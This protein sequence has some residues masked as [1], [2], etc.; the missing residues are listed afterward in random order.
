MSDTASAQLDCDV[1]IIGAGPTGL[2]LACELLRHGLS[3]RILDAVENPTTFSK[4]Q[5]LHT[6]TLEVLEQMGLVEDF[7]KKGRAL[8]LLSMY[9]PDLRRIFHFTVGEFDSAYP[10]MLSL[11]QHDTEQIL[12][13]HLAKHGVIVERPFHVERLQQED[14]SVLVFGTRGPQQTPAQV[15]A[16]WA[17]GCDGANSVVRH[18]LNIP[19]QGSTYRQRVLQADVK[20]EWPLY[21]AEDEVFGFVSE[22]GSLGV[23]PLPAEGRYRLVAL[24]AGLSPTPENFQYLLNT[25]GPKE[26]RITDAAWLHEYTIH[27][28]LATAFRQGRV[29]LAGDAAHTLS[30]STAQGMNLGI[31]DAFNLAWK[32]ALVHKHIGRDILLDSYEA[33]RSPVAAELMKTSDLATRGLNDLF[34][35]HG[36]LAQSM[37]NSLLQLVSEFGLVRRSIS[38]NLSMLD[39][40]YPNSPIVDQH[41]ASRLTRARGAS[42]EALSAG[43]KGTGANIGLRQWLD[44]GHGPSPGQRAFDGRALDVTSNQ[45]RS[46]YSLLHSGQ[47]LLLLFAGTVETEDGYRRLVAIGKHLRERHP[48]A[49]SVYLVEATLHSETPADPSWDGPTLLD[50]DGWLHQTYGA[51]AECL[52]LIRPDGHVAFR[53]QPADPIK[54][55][56][57]LARVFI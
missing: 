12:I 54:L 39:L 25:R 27:C 53:S 42:A 24:D 1:L 44:F 10:Y 18:E 13:D 57:F 2:A 35:L 45:K 6:R 4:A 21:H 31:Q 41:H 47:H 11:P 29:F 52:Y 15:R 3:C 8:H 14:G 46:L 28:R 51:R 56:E 5:I 30:P 40:G 37:R 16:A 22:H 36:S 32:L 34:T 49:I 38:R 48:S 55:D 17:V 7:L 23:F 26:A 33:E 9:T 19:W 20:L 50:E 43:P